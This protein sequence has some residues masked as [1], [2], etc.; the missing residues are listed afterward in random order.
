MY[1]LPVLNWR[2]EGTQRGLTPFDL[3]LLRAILLTMIK[4]GA[5]GGTTSTE[6]LIEEA[7]I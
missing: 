5:F 7:I 6:M 4:F 3:P 2:P 1:P